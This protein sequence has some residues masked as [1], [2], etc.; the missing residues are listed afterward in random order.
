MND[1]IVW[2]KS[3]MTIK[4]NNIVYTIG[5]LIDSGGFALVLEC[6]DSFYNDLVLKVFKP[7]NRPFKEVKKQWEKETE[8]FYRLRHPNI[9]TIYNSFTYG[10]LFYI[11]L[12][13]AEGNLISLLNIL[14]KFNSMQIYEV[15]RQLLFGLHFIHFNKIIHRDLT[16]YNVL[17]T[18]GK[19]NKQDKVIYKISDFGISKDLFDQW[20][21]SQIATTYIAHPDFIC[22]EL[23]NSGYTSQQSDLYHFGLILLYL[24]TGK[25]P[26]NLTRKRKEII[27][28]ILNGIPRQT[29]EKLGTPLGKYI[30]VFLRRHNDYRFK[31]AVHAWNNLIKSPDCFIGDKSILK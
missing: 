19:I 2:P 15:C 30:S 9:V 17:Y 5:N 29:A 21:S 25:C 12:E 4:V 6:K 16:I 22:P 27:K 8:L 24:Y 14:K 1:K 10:K 13:K 28:D 31:N 11:V 26:L 23:L 7:A 18:V 3:G 20:E